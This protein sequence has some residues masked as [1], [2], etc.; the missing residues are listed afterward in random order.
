MENGKIDSLKKHKHP[1]L[2][3]LVLVLTILNSDA[4]AMRLMAY[5]RQTGEKSPLP[6]TSLIVRVVEVEESIT[7]DANGE[8]DFNCRECLDE[9]MRPEIIYVK[10]KSIVIEQFGDFKL[11]DDVMV[12]YKINHLAVLSDFAK[13]C[14]GF[15]KDMVFEKIKN[16]SGTT[17]I[18]LYWLD[19]KNILIGANKQD[20][21]AVGATSYIG[22]TQYDLFSFEMADRIVKHNN[23]VMQTGK[24]L[25]QE[26]MIND[27]TTSEIKYFTSIKAPLYDNMG[28]S[29]GIL[30]T[31]VDITTEK[32]AECIK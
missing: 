15:T 10:N 1:S 17:P 23:L 7:T 9:S 19:E 27:I 31:S 29:I 24:V 12:V 14:S 26:E 3:L 25:S 18:N 4:S 22:K 13:Q 11:K 16:L 30:G 5:D 28:K 20:E 21:E 2:S 6:Y 8:F 32:N